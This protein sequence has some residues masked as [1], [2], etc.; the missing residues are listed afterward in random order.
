MSLPKPEVRARVPHEVHAMIKAHA[1]LHNLDMVDVV[2][3]I[4]TSWTM[5]QLDVIR[6]AQKALDAQGIPGILGEYKG[7]SGSDGE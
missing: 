1:D 3:A 4:L 6:L 7:A 2:N 5:K